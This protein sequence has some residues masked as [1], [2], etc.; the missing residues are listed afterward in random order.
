MV[1]VAT[2]PQWLNDILTKLDNS[3]AEE[4]PSARHASALISPTLRK[5]LRDVCLEL[6]HLHEERRDLRAQLAQMV[7]D[8]TE[9]ERQKYLL[10]Y[11]DGRAQAAPP[12][13]PR[14]G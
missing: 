8:R 10:G 4:G 13:R 12:L 9:A 14:E 7:A 1:D 3:S 2:W 11:E 6:H 5:N